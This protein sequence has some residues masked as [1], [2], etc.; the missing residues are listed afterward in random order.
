MVAIYLSFASF[1][2][3][4]L[5]DLSLGITGILRVFYFNSVTLGRGDQFYIFG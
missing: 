2:K 4:E 3:A 5:Q 1:E